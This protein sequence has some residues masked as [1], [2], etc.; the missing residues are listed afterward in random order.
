[1]HLA[2]IVRLLEAPDVQMLMARVGARRTIFLEFSKNLR[3]DVEKLLRL[4]ALRPA[5]LFYVGLFYAAYCFL[6]LKAQFFCHRNDLRFLA[7]V[8]WSAALHRKG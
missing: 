5:G 7:G 3:E 4:G 2:E 6:T 1:M 8:T